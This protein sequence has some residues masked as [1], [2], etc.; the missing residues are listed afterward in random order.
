MMRLRRMTRTVAATFSV[1]ALT[2][3][4]N[5]LSV[6]FNNPQPGVPHGPGA[7]IIYS[8]TYS[9]NQGESTVNLIGVYAMIGS[10]DSNI[11]TRVSS[12]YAHL[13]PSRTTWAG[14]STRKAPTRR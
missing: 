14:T 9:T 5:A 2:A 4:A 6:T 8:G 7:S 3:A 12:H 11:G 1:L 10:P 13:T